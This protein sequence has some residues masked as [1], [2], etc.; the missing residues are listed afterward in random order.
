MLRLALLLDV[1][2]RADIALAEGLVEVGP[3]DDAG[4]DGPKDAKDG[5]KAAGHGK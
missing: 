3:G 2:L 1:D 5:T 4:N